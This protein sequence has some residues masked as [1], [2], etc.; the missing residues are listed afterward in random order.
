MLL[1]ISFGSNY[2][3]EQLSYQ[4][5]RELAFVY[6]KSFYRIFTPSDLP[7]SFVEYARRYPRGYGYWI[8]K[9]WII[10]QVLNAL[11]PADVV[12][13]VDGRSGLVQRGRGVGWLNEFIQKPEF[14][15]VAWQ[16]DHIEKLWTTADLISLISGEDSKVAA[17][18]GQ[19]AATFHAWRPSANSKRFADLWLD[20]LVKNPTLCRDESSGLTN[21]PAF[22]ENRHD[23]SVFSLLLK[24]LQKNSRLNVLSL[25]N[26]NLY[27]DNLLPHRKKH[28]PP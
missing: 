16:M 22:K 14:D 19:Y 24:E 23:Q 9:P 3:Y 13:Y 2:K 28:P 26:N 1:F 27:A 25:T 11:N 5:V 6:K 21:D 8:W 18:S 17:D 20:F 12:L 10:R 7:A 4:V 15:L